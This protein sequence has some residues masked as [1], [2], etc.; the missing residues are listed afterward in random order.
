MFLTTN[1]VLILSGSNALIRLNPV[2]GVSQRETYQTYLVLFIKG[3]DGLPLLFLFARAGFEVI[4][5]PGLFS[6]TY[7]HGEFILIYS[8]SKIVLKLKCFFFLPLLCLSHICLQ[9]SCC[10]PS[11]ASFS[12]FHFL[13]KG[14]LFVLVTLICT[15]SIWSHLDSVWEARGAHSVPCEFIPLPSIVALILV[16]FYW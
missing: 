12:S 11:D 5:Y 2:P 8:Y 14:G 4:L 1:W 16:G 13:S 3:Q 7:F 10:I 9:E 15:C 6:N